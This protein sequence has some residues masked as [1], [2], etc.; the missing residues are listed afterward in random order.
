MDGV[1]WAL[2]LLVLLSAA[3]GALFALH[4]TVYLPTKRHFARVNAGMDTLLG[5]PAV[6]DPG[7]GREIQPATPPLAARV[8]DLEQANMKMADA[9]T[10][11]ADN[12]QR[13]LALENAWQ[14]RQRVGQAI[15][16]DFTAWREQVDLALRRWVEEQDELARLLREHVQKEIDE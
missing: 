16:E 15:V 8:Y 10:L 13:I 4:R 11:L 7:S 2:E 3:V 14:E 5:Y 1:P 12:Q 6:K 9:M